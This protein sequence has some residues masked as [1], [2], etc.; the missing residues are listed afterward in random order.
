MRYLSLNCRGLSSGIISY[1]RS[2]VCN[3]WPLYVIGKAIYIYF[4]PVVSS[5]SSSSSSS[6]FLQR[7][8]CSH[9]KRCISYSNSVCLSV[10]LSVRPSVRLSVTRRYCVNTAIFLVISH[11]NI[12]FNITFSRFR[13]SQGSVARLIRRV[14]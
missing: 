3:L 4:H 1:L 11:C 10:R 14:G 9:C 7:A 5:S 12:T 2:V 6:F 8:Q 13:L